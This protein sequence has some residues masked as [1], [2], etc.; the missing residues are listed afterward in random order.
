[1]SRLGA[2]TRLAGPL[3]GLATAALTVLALELTF[4]AADFDFE[5][6]RK[7][8][9]RLPIF[10][11]QPVVPVGP[12][13]Y[14]RPGPARWEGKVIEPL[15]LQKGATDGAYRDE[16]AVVVEYDQLGFRNPTDLTDWD[17][18]AVGD[19]FTELGFLPYEALFT[20]RLGE[21]LGVRVKNLGVS[22]T[23]TR[24][25]IFYLEEYGRSPSLHEAVLVFFEG[26]DFM[27]IRAED[28]RLRARR[29]GIQPADDAPHTLV[30]EL[31]SQS[32]LLTAAYRLVVRE[33]IRPVNL[34]N[35]FFT[36]TRPWVPVTVEL[37]VPPLAKRPRESRAGAA[38]REA[39]Q[40]WADAARRIGARPWLAL[41]P[42]KQRVL[43]GHLLRAGKRGDTRTGRPLSP[44][45]DDVRTFLAD[46]AEAGGLGFID[47]T[48]ALRRETEAGRLT[49]NAVMDTHLNRLGS[50][51]VA[52]TLAEAL[53]GGGGR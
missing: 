8:F 21:L 24:T 4:R 22:F 11:R 48:P 49:Y 19:S 47:L 40:A 18:V 15:Y 46:V 52:R 1:M 5:F 20:T 35:A 50:E 53:A 12:A 43:D 14:R 25:H 13:F 44:L 51:V 34:A 16:P 39:I 26:N 30:D 38:A 23:G 6:K 33:P 42:C 36:A 27:D 17:I 31:P 10:Y 41:M 28:A 45:P 37:G 9:A 29:D 7:A 32:S 2:R 3:L